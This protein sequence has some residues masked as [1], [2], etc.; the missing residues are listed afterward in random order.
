MTAPAVI[1]TVGLQCR[2]EDE[3]VFNA[4]YDEVHVPMLLAG[5][6]V[7]GVTRYKLA[8]G[9][10][11]VAPGSIECPTYQTVYEFADREDFES[12]MNGKARSA[13]G[14]DKTT[15]WAE[16]PY[17]VVWAGSYERMATTTAV[18]ITTA[19]KEG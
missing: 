4:W 11:D 12:W 5:G 6:H 16:H 13:A 2:P 14:E 3:D 8:S 1:W 9:T 7:A 17:D 18:T 15:T 10:H 19:P